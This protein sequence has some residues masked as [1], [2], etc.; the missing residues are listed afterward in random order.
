MVKTK[1][2]T[3]YLFLYKDSK[4]RKFFNFR[5]KKYLKFL[6]GDNFPIAVTKN[7]CIK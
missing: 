7:S 2:E 6:N 4:I 3:S 5:A 1:T